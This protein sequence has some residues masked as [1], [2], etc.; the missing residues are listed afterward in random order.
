M[1]GLSE[2]R[3]VAFLPYDETQGKLT[4]PL[5]AFGDRF[6]WTMSVLCN[7]SRRYKRR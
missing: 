6:C 7:G 4:F 2:A 5:L 1:A 3:S